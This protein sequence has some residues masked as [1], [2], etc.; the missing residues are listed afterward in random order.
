MEKA[1]IYIETQ[2]PL[3][4]SKSSRTCF[5]SM[6]VCR[7]NMLFTALSLLL[8]LLLLLF[9][10]PLITMPAKVEDIQLF[11]VKYGK[12]PYTLLGGERA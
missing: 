3:I 6:G 9:L 10:P 8:L 5:L 1:N 7:I 2:K 4:N 11:S 12:S